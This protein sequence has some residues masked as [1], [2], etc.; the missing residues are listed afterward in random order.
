[1]LPHK[2]EFEFQKRHN[3]YL[4]RNT[5]S[6]Q[7]PSHYFLDWVEMKTSALLKASSSAEVLQPHHTPQVIGSFNIP[8]GKIPSILRSL[9]RWIFLK[10]ISQ[11]RFLN[12]C[13]NLIIFLLSSMCLATILPD[14][15]H[16]GSSLTHFWTIHKSNFLWRA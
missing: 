14:P 12:N 3:I 16:E 4:S 10:T 6:T 11:E 2:T 13:C 1:V 7:L 8:R 9:N 15:F 5:L